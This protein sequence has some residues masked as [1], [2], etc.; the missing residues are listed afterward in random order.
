MIDMDRL[1]TLLRIH[2]HG[3]INGLT[4]YGDVLHRHHAIL[5]LL[6]DVLSTR[7]GL[8]IDNFDRSLRSAIR[9]DVGSI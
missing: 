2:H 3:L 1:L 5:W 6:M 4:S 9:N 7:L 8:I